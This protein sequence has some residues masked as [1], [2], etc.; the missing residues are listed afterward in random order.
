MNDNFI[1]D[2]DK[3][4]EYNIYFYYP[5]LVEDTTVREKFMV[6]GTNVLKY[7][8][9]PNPYD[10]LSEIMILKMMEHINKK[11]INENYEIVEINEKFNE[12]YTE[13]HKSRDLIYDLIVEI[14]SGKKIIDNSD[15]DFGTNDISKKYLDFMRD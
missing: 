5:Y 11:T 2:I 4:R 13:I 6:D 10:H 8:T 1:S 12:I 15:E 3:I 7:L 9:E 14:A